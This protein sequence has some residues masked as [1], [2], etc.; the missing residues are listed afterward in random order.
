MKL[1]EPTSEMHFFIDVA[2][3]LGVFALCRCGKCNRREKM[4]SFS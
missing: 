2:Y 4:D 1:F 3:A